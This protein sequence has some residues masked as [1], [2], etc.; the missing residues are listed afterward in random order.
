MYA[1]GVSL[2]AG[3]LSNYMAFTKEKCPFVAA[4]GLGCHYDTIK[5]ME[6]LR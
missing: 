1:L 4:F 5:A 3:I 6:F 2:G